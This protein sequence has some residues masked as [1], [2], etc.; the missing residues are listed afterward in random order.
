MPTL[1][2]ALAVAHFAGQSLREH[3]GLFEAMAGDM[4]WD[5]E[6]ID[7]MSDADAKLLTGLRP[8]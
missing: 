6:P 1:Y 3:K 8:S 7:G 4:N 2:S 5:G